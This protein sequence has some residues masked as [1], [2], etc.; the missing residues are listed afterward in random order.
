MATCKYCGLPIKFERL[1]SGRW[2]PK[3]WDGSDHFDLCKETTFKKSDKFEL[4]EETS[5]HT[6]P[7]D[8]FDDFY[9]GEVPP[10]DDSLGDFQGS[11]ADGYIVLDDGI[12]TEKYLNPKTGVIKIVETTPDSISSQRIPPK[13]EP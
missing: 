10:W 6:V 7:N 1:P 12:K 8:P 13:Q 4:I 9:D 3:N 5:A 2:C 11:T